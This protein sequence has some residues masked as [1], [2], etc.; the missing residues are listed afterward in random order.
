MIMVIL[1]IFGI[2][3]N[4]YLI[5]DF[6]KQIPKYKVFCYKGRF[7]SIPWYRTFAIKVFFYDQ[8]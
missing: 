3:Y 7:I 6:V 5:K 8:L 4:L 1:L 2:L